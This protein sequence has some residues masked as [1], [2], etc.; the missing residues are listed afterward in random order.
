MK[1]PSIIPWI[2]GVASLLIL[3]AGSAAAQQPL[4]LTLGGAARYAAARSA[5]SEAARYRVDLAEARERQEHAD[6]L[7]TFAGALSVGGRTLNSAGFGLALPD[8][9]T[10]SDLF[11]PAGEVLGPIRAWD[12]RGTVRQTL[13]DLASFARVGAARADVAVADADAVRVSEEAAAT[14]AMLYVSALSADERLSARQADSTLAEEL[15]QIARSQREAGMGI[16]LDVTRARAQV[17]AAGAQLIAARTERERVRLQLRDALGLRLDTP[18]ELADSLLKMSTTFQTPLDVETSSRGLR[19]RADLRMVEAQ[20]DAAERRL[21]AVRK[22]RLPSLSFFAD[23]GST[24]SS[25]TRMLKTYSW[26]VQVSV[27]VFDGLR[28]EGR[29]AEQR[30]AIRELE[31]RRRDVEQQVLLDRRVALLELASSAERLKAAG[32]RLALAEQELELARRRFVLGVAGNADVITALLGL[33]V[34]R[35]ERIDALA[36]LQSA[37]VTLALAEGLVTQM[38]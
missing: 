18:L 29:I 8:P 20:V 23:W 13:V 10:G 26:G 4:T 2:A 3:D 25:T 33:N 7:P 11:D 6:L 12:M 5:R 19:V 35:T 24:G 31:A 22:E 28:R 21:G 16:A 17:A 15:L 32:K 37:R 27:P 30:S 36:A 38:P 14:A 1:N 9:T 34:A